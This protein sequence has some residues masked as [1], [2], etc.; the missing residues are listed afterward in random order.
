LEKI[1][2]LVVEDEALIRMTAVQ[3]LEDAGYRVVEARNADAALE[4][5][6]CRNDIRCVFTDIKMPG[7]MDGLELAHAIQDRW[8]PICL[9]IA[10]GLNTPIEDEFP[11][12]ARFI[13]KP[14]GPKHIL[15]ALSEL[16]SPQP[17]PYRYSRNATQNMI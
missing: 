2:I 10:S 1:V 6:K 5:L 9:L 3:V 12:I 17:A 7:L 8:P 14:Y 4:I 11:H 15:K 16:L 13:R